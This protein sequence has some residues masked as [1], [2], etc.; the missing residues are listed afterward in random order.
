MIADSPPAV[1]TL[2]VRAPQLPP[3]P[4]DAAFSIIQLPPEVLRTASRLD[5]ALELEPGFS[6]YRRLSS[7]GA[8]PTTQ[9]V[10]LRGI[11]GSAASRALVTLDGVPQNDPFGGW[12]IFTAQPPETIGSATV[13]RG[14]GSGPYGAG[15]LTGVVSL[16]T[17]PARAGDWLVDGQGGSL[18]W[19]RAAGT[20]TVALGSTLATFSAAAETS[21]GWDPIRADRGPADDNL[22]LQ[23]YT[24]SGRFQRDFGAAVAALR[25]SA[26]QEDRGA[27]EV[28]AG[29]RA[30][31]AQVSLTAEAD[32]T[33]SAFGWRAQ[34]W[35]LGSDLANTSVTV[36][37]NQQTSTPADNEFQTPALGVG[38]NA[39]ARRVWAHS[40]LELGA[41]V[42]A[43]GGE[44][45]ETY[46]NVDGALTK[47]RRAGGETVI[48]GAYAEATQ[49]SGRLLLAEGVRL[50]DWNT[51]DGHDIESAVSTPSQGV[52][53]RTPARAG[54]TPSGRLALR[55]DVEDDFWLRAAA[56][57][58]FRTPTLNELFRTYRVGNDVTEANA[59]LVPERLYGVEG[60][61]GGGG[62]L[63]GWNLTVFYNRLDDPVTN[64]TLQD[65]PLTNPAVGF[66]PA[67]G[68]LLERENVGAIDA[69][70]V[71]AEGEIH[72]R[73]SL[74]LRLAVDWTH[75][76]VDGGTAAADLDGLQ[77]AETPATAAT[78][79]LD[80]TP[81]PRLRF[82]ADVRY[83]A[84]RYV[85]DQ[86]KLPL[87]AATVTDVRIEYSASSRLTL[88]VAAD[89]LFDVAVEQNETTL[90]L[91]SYGAPRIVSA[92]FRLTNRR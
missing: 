86:N 39:E 63:L 6:L 16:A 80:W 54:L 25:I 71:E 46:D 31:G 67:G 32:P 48:A 77:P 90:G 72:L 40:T 79:F 58:G 49:Q 1:E 82:V 78:A 66:I 53:T 19:G 8:N 45:R 81:V 34:A 65:G 87:A 10:S 42:R 43:D 50:D 27:G 33:P 36:P 13:V 30:R 61:A 57:S 69:Y 41:D 18:D 5:D 64:V 38:A 60:G 52:D 37:A 75:A 3:S 83:E 35:A 7:L 70:G 91:Y 88:F 62:R 4:A 14:A 76:R 68:A 56:Y 23:D 12:V 21:N 59:A 92:G 26:Y 20:G 44:D 15:A 24:A 73:P 89:N 22:T 47:L 74:S 51:F 55:Y 9:G 85:D 17:P 28:G 11:A 84:R 2:V 29:S